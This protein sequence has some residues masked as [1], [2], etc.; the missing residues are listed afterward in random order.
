MALNV[1]F[2]SPLEINLRWEAQ[3]VSCAVGAISR[4]Q[5]WHRHIDIIIPQALNQEHAQIL[6]S[7]CQMPFDAPMQRSQRY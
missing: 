1:T 6:T 2:D 5:D 4:Q 7:A 3:T